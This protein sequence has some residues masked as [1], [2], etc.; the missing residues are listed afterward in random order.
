MNTRVLLAGVLGGIAMFL[1]SFVAHDLLPL[2]QMG[3]SKL[4]HEATVIEALY[5]DLG[6]RE[7]L[8]LYPAPNAPDNA[9]SAEKKEAMQRAID[10][11]QRGPSGMLIYHPQRDLNMGRLL[12][13]EFVTELIEAIL[14]AFLLAQTG[15]VSYVSRVFFVTIIGVI[16]AITT[17]I[18]YWN[19]YAFPKRFTAAAIF[20]Q[21]V[22]FFLVGLISAW[23]VRSK[24][25]EMSPA[26]S[27]R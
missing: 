18:P 1:W 27:S 9:T 14:A 26:D 25:G 24:T 8:F 13:V 21:V 11:S 7:G 10:K 5:T 20:I 12:G 3:I 6:S 2:G 17:N 15:L 19:W 23:L 16:A 22:G 4:S